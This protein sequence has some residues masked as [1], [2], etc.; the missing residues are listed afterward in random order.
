[1]IFLCFVIFY[2][3]TAAK[4]RETQI[5]RARSLFK[6]NLPTSEKQQEKCENILLFAQTVKI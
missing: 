3:L 2:V 4:Q 1:M 6:S 5:N